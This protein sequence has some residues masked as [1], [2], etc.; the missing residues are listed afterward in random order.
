MHFKFRDDEGTNDQSPANDK[1]KLTFSFWNWHVDNIEQ[2]KK[3][4]NLPRP[5]RIIR[6][7]VLRWTPPSVPLLVRSY[8]W[9]RYNTGRYRASE[10]SLPF[11]RPTLEAVCNGSRPFPRASINRRLV[12]IGKFRS[13]VDTI[14][15]CRAG[16]PVVAPLLRTF[17]RAARFLRSGCPK[18]CWRNRWAKRLEKPPG[19]SSSVIERRF[20]SLTDQAFRGFMAEMQRW[21]TSIQN[22]G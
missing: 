8:N 10:S 2:N 18:V 12:A 1:M 4:K 17:S 7:S 21:F 22:L 15:A 5:R 9:Q 11:P 16:R 6:M 14:Y 13:C 19:S 3:E 20:D